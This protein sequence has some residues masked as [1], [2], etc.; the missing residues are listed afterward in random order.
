MDITLPPAYEGAIMGKTSNHPATIDYMGDIDDPSGA[1]RKRSFE[2]SVYGD[3]MVRG[4]VRW[5]GDKHAQ[6]TSEAVTTNA[7]VYISV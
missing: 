4:R 1:G 7:P 3:G 2:K 5:D 6:G